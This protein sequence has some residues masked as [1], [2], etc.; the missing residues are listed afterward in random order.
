MFGRIGLIALSAAATLAVA[1]GCGGSA[2]PATF[3]APPGVTTNIL[4]SGRLE[5]IPPGT[6]FVNYLKLP[7]AAAG[8]IKHKHLAGFVYAVEGTVEV[9]VEGAAPLI[10]PPGQAAF[11]GANIMHNHLNSGT[12]ANDWWFVALRP[13][14]SRPLATIVS[15]Q[16]ELYTTADLT[17]INA[18][19]YTETLSN[20]L[21]PA[22]G[23]DRQTGQSLRVLYVL[24]GNV[25]LSGDAAMAGTVSAGQG[26]YSLPGANLVM[27]AGSTGGHYLIF[28][29]TPAS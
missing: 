3:K 1:V 6:L 16:K 9:D 11:I 28:T 14:A 7:Q 19:P 27:T 23:V 26:A 24:D 12:V 10:I 25:T 13:A 20:N 15:G 17:Q 5:S 22:N 18:S 4:A 2:T 29:L 8:S 21:L